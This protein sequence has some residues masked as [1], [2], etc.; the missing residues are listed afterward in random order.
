MKKIIFLLIVVLQ[1]SSCVNRSLFGVSSSRIQDSNQNNDFAIHP[2]EKNSL[3]DENGLNIDD[4]SGSRGPSPYL[5]SR[6]W[7]QLKHDATFN[8]SPYQ[9]RP[10]SIIQTMRRKRPDNPHMEKLTYLLNKI[11]NF[12]EQ[13]PEPPETNF[14]EGNKKRTHS[15]F[16]YWNNYLARN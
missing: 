5:G 2:D 9:R 13:N 3:G 4:T 1:R 10:L 15:L 6:M 16:G 11:D 12:Y 8:V 7:Q 14:E